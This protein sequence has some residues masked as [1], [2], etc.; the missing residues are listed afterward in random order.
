MY[1]EIFQESFLYYWSIKLH[2]F[3]LK[4]SIISRKFT[5]LTILI[6]NA[7]IKLQ[8]LV[9]TFSKFLLMTNVWQYLH[10]CLII[11][12]DVETNPICQKD[13]DKSYLSYQEYWRASLVISRILES[14]ILGHIYQLKPMITMMSLGAN[15]KL[16][17]NTLKES[18]Y[19]IWSKVA[20]YKI[21]I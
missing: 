21:S 1:M 20:M 5:Y 4:A 10:F 3:Y 18:R 15:S 11:S 7:H 6:I 16:I 12:G 2:V 17:N 19:T 13:L 8:N 9:K 14:N